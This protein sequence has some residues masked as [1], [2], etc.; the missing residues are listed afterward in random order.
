MT[1]KKQD[2]RRRITDYLRGLVD[3]WLTTALGIAIMVVLY[4]LADWLFKLPSL[5]N[6]VIA[7][8]G[9]KFIARIIDV[10]RGA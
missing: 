9:L 8:F 3:S 4:Y 10:V 5:I 1:L 7:Y 6:L 2:I